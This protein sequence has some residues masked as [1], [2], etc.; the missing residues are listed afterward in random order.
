MYYV[1]LCFFIV[2]LVTNILFHVYGVENCA[3]F[4]AGIRLSPA[5]SILKCILLLGGMLA[6]RPD[7][8]NLKAPEMSK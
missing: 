2:M 8:N 5:I 1:I 3:C 6:I 4:G 7:D